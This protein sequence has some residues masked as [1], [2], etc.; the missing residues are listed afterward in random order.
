MSSVRL[1][2]NGGFTV[3]PGVAG[4]T[5]KAASGVTLTDAATGGDHTTTLTAGKTYVV[6]TNATGGMIFGIAAVTT[7]ANIIWFL[8]PNSIMSFHMPVGYTTLHY[9]GLVNDSTCYLVEL[10]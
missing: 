6:M 2:D 9:A 8:P 10:E 3:P 4:F 5:P 7:A 1:S